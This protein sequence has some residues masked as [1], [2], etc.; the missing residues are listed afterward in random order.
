MYRRP[1]EIGHGAQLEDAVS[2]APSP[3]KDC[4][5]IVPTPMAFVEEQSEQGAA[6][7]QIGVAGHPD[8]ALVCRRRNDVQAYRKLPPTKKKQTSEKRGGH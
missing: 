2:P 3:L 4:A 8:G 6:A 7:D 5:R 1:E